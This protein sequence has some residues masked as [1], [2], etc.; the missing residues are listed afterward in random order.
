MCHI[1]H[2]WLK[3]SVEVYTD[4]STKAARPR[5]WFWQFEHAEAFTKFMSVF[6]LKQ[7]PYICIVMM[8]ENTFCHKSYEF[9]CYAM[10]GW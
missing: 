8:D 7:N 10:C 4:S 2:K 6:N 3:Q 5:G 1:F 9:Y